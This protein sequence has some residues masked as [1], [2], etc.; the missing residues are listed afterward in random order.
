MHDADN[1]LQVLESIF[2]IGFR[3]NQVLACARDLGLPDCWIAAG[4]VRN[5]VWDLREGSVSPVNDVDV[6][7]FDSMNIAVEADAAIEDRLRLAM[8]DIPW[9]VKNQARMHLRN[10]HPPYLSCE[11]ALSF[12][13]ETA[14]AV[15]VRRTV[16]NELALMAPFGLDD[17]FDGIV[18]PTPWVR[19]HAAQVFHARCREKDWLGQ[20]PSLHVLHD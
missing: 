17:L 5:A 14:T 9:S 8:P 3:R 6:I 13:P 18:R 11:H 1:R 2:R 16:S 15:A 10:G 19:R 20:W 4:F 7:Y 12:W